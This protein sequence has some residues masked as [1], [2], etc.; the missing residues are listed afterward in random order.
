MGSSASCSFASPSVAGY[1]RLM[2]KS[3]FL[4]IDVLKPEEEQFISA[5]PL[6]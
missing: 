4:G 5:T 1:S 3:M 2:G 6:N